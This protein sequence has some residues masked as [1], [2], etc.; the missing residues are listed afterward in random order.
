MQIFSK[1]KKLTGKK[2]QLKARTVSV[3]KWDRYT[4]RQVKNNS[5]AGGAA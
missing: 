1:I 2:E 4:Q 3:I 5:F